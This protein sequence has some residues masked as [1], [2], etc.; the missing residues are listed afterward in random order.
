MELHIFG[1]R[2]SIPSPSTKH[3]KTDRYG[4]NTTCYLIKS[5]N[6]ELHIVD[7]GTGIRVLGNSLMK[8]KYTGDINLYIT[9]THWDHIQG[10]PFFAPAYH[11]LNQ[12]KIFGEAKIGGDLVAALEKHSDNPGYFPDIPRTLKIN[13][14][15]IK[16]VLA[17]QQASRNFPAPLEV[18]KGLKDFVDFIA[19]GIVYRSGDLTVEATRINHPGGCI[20]YKFSEGGKSLVIATDF[21]PDNNGLDNR[22]IEWFKDADIVVADAQYEKGSPINPFQVG[23]GHSDYVTDIELCS[24]ANVRKL[25]LGHHEPKM[26][27][28]YLGNLEERAIILGQENNLNVSLAREEDIYKI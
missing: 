9:H 2:G 24:K 19:P 5:N 27:D 25:V 17:Q 28:S 21:E 11:P 8:E 10:L 12:V 22:I 16:D 26:D 7:A 18:M 15:G 14:Y 13:G 3:F 23:W 1:S 4:G 6:G 20:S